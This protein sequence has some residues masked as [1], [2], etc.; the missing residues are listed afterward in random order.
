MFNIGDIVEKVTGDY[1]V[2][3][4]V[5]AAFTTKAGKVRYAVEH[6]H[7]FLHIYSEHNLKLIQE[8]NKG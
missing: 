8:Y 4:E 3:G 2:D 1:R 6:D 5:R 7:G